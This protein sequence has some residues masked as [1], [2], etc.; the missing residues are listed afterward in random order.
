LKIILIAS[1]SKNRIIGKEGSLPWNSK[2]D[3]KH[4]QNTTINNAVLMGRKTFESI[5]KPLINR[6]NIVVSNNLRNSITSN[7]LHFVS[8][9]E[10]GI[11]FAQ[12]QN[13]GDLFII[14]GGEIYAQTI[15]IAD[16]LIISHFPL[17]VEGDTSFPNI[18]P[19]LWEIKKTIDM[20]TFTIT[21]Y[22]K[23][24]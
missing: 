4:F 23:R 19:L 14:G 3:L 18:E 12:I 20:K 8:N 5:G 15:Q 21:Y 7:N 9:I 16:E 17:I 22:S 13:T 1:V 24:T 10:Q 11:E 6:M 2:S